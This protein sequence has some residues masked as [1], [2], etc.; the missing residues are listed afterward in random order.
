MR[1]AIELLK[2]VDQRQQTIYRVCQAIVD[3]Q[4]GFLEK[5]YLSLK[6]MLIKDIAEELGVHSSTISRVVSNKYAHTPQG[7]IELRKFFTVGVEGVG[8]ENVSTIQVKERIRTI[9]EDEN[10][11]KPLSDQKIAKIL[12]QDGIQI[13]RRTVAKYRDQMNIAGSRDRK[14]AVMF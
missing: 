14:M 8:G 13:T 4:P 10:S 12:N 9:I 1:S 11:Q 5:G 7:I 3:R 6:P 2:S